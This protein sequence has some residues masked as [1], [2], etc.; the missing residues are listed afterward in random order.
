[1]DF[2]KGT[3]LIFSIKGIGRKGCK[4]R[5]LNW[6]DSFK[7]YRMKANHWDFISVDNS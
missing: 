4:V 1:M 7:L 3:K 2:Q 6:D 5:L